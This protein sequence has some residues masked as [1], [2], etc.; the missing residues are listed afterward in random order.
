M[1]TAWRA[2]SKSGYRFCGSNQACADSVDLNLAMIAS[3]NRI[4]QRRI[5][6]ARLQAAT[7]VP[8]WQVTPVPPSP[9]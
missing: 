3:A 9:Q 2:I 1:L 4:P 5:I 7:P 6:R 8:I